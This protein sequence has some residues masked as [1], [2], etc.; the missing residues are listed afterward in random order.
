MKIV[1]TLDTKSDA[2]LLPGVLNQKGMEELDALF[3]YNDGSLD[4]TEEILFSHPRVTAYTN[5]TTI[6]RRQWL[7]DKVRN[8]FPNEEVWIIRLEGDRFWINE[9]P[10]LTVSLALDRG[11]DYR[12]GVVVDFRPTGCRI[13]DVHV[14]VAF[15]LT[16]QLIYDRARPWPSGLGTKGDYP[17]EHNIHEYMCY[18]RH[19]GYRTPEYWCWSY[20]SGN[21]P[22]PSKY[23]N[24]DLSSPEAAL[25]TAPY[26]FNPSKL[27]QWVSFEESI[28]KLLSL[29]REELGQRDSNSSVR[30]IK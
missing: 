7:L 25:S 17:G 24:W 3:A 11:W 21:R 15:K 27:V 9:T 5:H 20:N 30:F 16:P 10:K 23:P 19:E 2:D 4:S 13:D 6:P 29:W 8:E 22:K 18:L 14:A 1:G 26:Q 12:A 28:E